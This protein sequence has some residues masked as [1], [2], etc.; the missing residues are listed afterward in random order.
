MRLYDYRVYDEV[1][2][3]EE[4]KSLTEWI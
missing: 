1:M 2:T 3:N 4:L